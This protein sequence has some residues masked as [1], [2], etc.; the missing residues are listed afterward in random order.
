M[1]NGTAVR[2][3]IVAALIP[4][5]YLGAN[6]VQASLQPPGTDMPDWTFHDL[7]MQLGQLA[8]RRRRR[9]IRK[10]PC[11]PGP[12]WTR[13]SNAPTTTTR[14]TS[15]AC[16]PRCST[17]R[18]TASSIARWSAITAAGWTRLSEEKNYLQLPVE[19]TKLPEKLTIPVSVSTWEN[20][21]DNKKVHGRLLVSAWQALPFRTVGLGTQD[22]LVAGGQAEV[23]RRDQSDDGNSDRR[24]G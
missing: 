14:D 5:T 4:L 7:P 9:W 6:R 3:G 8:R 1:I 20:E 16:M 18:P 23:A 21:R 15:S 22:P 2:V 10:S 12:S 24:G 13:S 19:L 11:K 17:I